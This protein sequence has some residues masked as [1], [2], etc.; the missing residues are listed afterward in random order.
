MR[1]RRR[2]GTEGSELPQ[3]ALNKAEVVCV[4][5]GD[6]IVISTR[7]GRMA[8][9]SGNKAEVGSVRRQTWQGAPPS[10]PARALYRLRTQN[11]A[12]EGGRERER[13]EEEHG[14]PAHASESLR[15]GD[16]RLMR[17]RDMKGWSGRGR[18]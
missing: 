9:V 15:L 18:G 1:G 14:L 6:Y 17:V 10:R 13:E 8:A 5:V 7:A 12:R 3:I 11:R 4:T 2:D 16:G